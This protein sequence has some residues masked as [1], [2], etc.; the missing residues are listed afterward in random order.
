MKKYLFEKNTLRKTI[1]IIMSAT[2]KKSFAT[3]SAAVNGMKLLFVFEITKIDKLE[4]LPWI[5]FLAFRIDMSK[6]SSV[7]RLLAGIA[8]SM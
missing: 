3:L 8:N 5:C 2:N 7:G 6:A 1:K 4:C